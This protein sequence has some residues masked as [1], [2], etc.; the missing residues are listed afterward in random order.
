MRSAMGDVFHSG[1]LE[2]QDQAG[3]RDQAAKIGSGIRA[4]ITADRQGFLLARRF[5]VVASTDRAGA[6]WASLLTGA[7]GFL[8]PVD[9]RRLRVY[10]RPLDGDPLAEGL[11]DGADVGMVAIDLANRK[12]LRINGRVAMREDGFDVVT[13]EVFGNCPKY[14]QARAPEGPD[15]A[16]AA[17]VATSAT[18]LDERQRRWVSEADTFFIGSRHA[19]RGADASHRGGTPGF[20]CVVSR[21]RL[22]WPDY[23]G[24]R[25]FQTLG[26]LARDAGAGL[27]FIDFDAGRT[28]QLA[29][30]ATVDWD[31][32]RTRGFAGAERV[33]DFAIDRV[34]E[35]SGRDDV[36]HRLLERSPFNPG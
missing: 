28:L 19:E 11:V 9:A 4:E 5:V 13:R 23:S 12:R 18:R 32:E 20:V 1:E 27:L 25:M 8:E 22:S 16:A 33:I 26:N 30:R 6:V 31:P 7:P 24:N 3:V 2:V 10:S 14:I 17:P 36:R 35:I 29:G 15:G 34:L 21:S